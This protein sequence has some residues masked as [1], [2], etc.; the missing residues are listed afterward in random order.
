MN[1][2][3]IELHDA[4]LHRTSIDYE[5]KTVLVELDFYASE[6][7]SERKRAE[8]FFGGVASVSHLADMVR[9]ESHASAGNVNY[10]VPATDGPTYI[11]LSDGCLAIT[12]RSIS[13]KVAE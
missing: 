6:K 4:R 11:Y 9:L 8:I 5:A 3:Q 7:S 13:F 12:A 2:E 1:L 10:W